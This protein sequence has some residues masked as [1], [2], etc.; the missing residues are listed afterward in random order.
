M[1]RI[2]IFSSIYDNR[3]MGGAELAVK[4]ITDRIAPDEIEFHMVTLR[5]D[6]SLPRLE[7]VGNVLVHRLGFTG[8]NPVVGDVRRFPLHYNKYLFPFLGALFARKLYARHRYDAIWSIQANYAGFAALFF[9]IWH[10]SVPFLL[11]LQEGDPIEHYKRRVGPLLFLYR[12]IFLSADAIQAISNYLAQIA[13]EM[14]YHGSLEVVPNGV[15]VRRFSQPR[16]EEEIRALKH[17]LNKKTGDIFLITTSRLEEKNAVGDIISAITFLPSTFK[18]LILGQGQEELKLKE[19]ARRLRVAERVVFLGYVKQTDV[20]LYLQISDI[21]VRPSR[22]EGMGS[23]FVEA[24]AA[25]IPVIATPVGGI[26]DFLHDGETGLFCEVG[27]PKSIAEKV[28][29][30]LQNTE[31]TEQIVKNAKE[32]VRRQYDWSVIADAM[33]KV[34]RSLAE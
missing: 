18:L 8:R 32:M 23:S 16:R 28:Q 17:K 10:S 31:L 20:P 9:K 27:N 22:S 25:G 30:Y 26:V 1:R 14:G 5:F 3:F 6:S 7:R 15:D 33:T 4:E 11:T 12:K 19:L 29:E 21:F 24:M 13:R 2:L 34:F